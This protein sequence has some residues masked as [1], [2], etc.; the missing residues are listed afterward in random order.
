MPLY[1]VTPGSE[2]FRHRS[3][4]FGEVQAH[5]LLL[6]LKQRPL[7]GLS[8]MEHDH[9]AVMVQAVFEVRA[10]SSTWRPMSV[11]LKG[12]SPTITGA[13]S[14][15]CSRFQWPAISNIYAHVSNLQH[16]D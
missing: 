12:P 7:R 2:N 15:K 3:A 4:P 8:A 6:A 11:A 14:T 16:S 1:R 5:R 10:N 9:L 13:T